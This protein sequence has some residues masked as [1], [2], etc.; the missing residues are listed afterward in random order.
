MLSAAETWEE[1]LKW[2]NRSLTLISSWLAAVC[3]S[4]IKRIRRKRKKIDRLEKSYQ[5]EEAGK[6][7]VARSLHGKRFFTVTFFAHWSGRTLTICNAEIWEN[8]TGAGEGTWE[9]TVR[10]LWALKGEK[11]LRFAWNWILRSG[12]ITKSWSLVLSES[13][14]TYHAKQPPWIDWEGCRHKLLKFHLT[15]DQS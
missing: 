2:M 7:R 8:G 6:R 10:V 5:Q 11:N 4:G 3:R 14:H 15:F 12:M 9:R 13:L 1:V